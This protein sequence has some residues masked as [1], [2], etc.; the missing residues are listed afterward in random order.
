VVGILVL[1]G[2][3]A[4]AIQNDDSNIEQLSIS[5]SQPILKNEEQ[6]IT[7][8]VNEANSF[9]MSQGKPMLPSYEQS[10]K[11]PFG[12]KIKSVTVTPKNIQEITL[13]KK[14]TPTP[15]MVQVGQKVE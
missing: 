3:G 2:L 5:F 8:N 11:Y 13:I 14:V 1:S 12:T 9:L 10:F 15:K 6:Y 7:V 4:V